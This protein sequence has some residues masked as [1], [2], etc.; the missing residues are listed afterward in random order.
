MKRR[1]KS[2]KN[3]I[4][5][6]FIGLAFFQIAVTVGFAKWHLEPSI[7]KMYT[8]HLDRFADVALEQIVSETEKVESYMVNIIGDNSIQEFLKQSNEMQ[9]QVVSPA[10]STN[11]RNKILK[12]TEYDNI[13]QAIYLV[14]NSGRVYS[15]LAQKQMQIFLEQHQDLKYRKNASAIWCGGDKLLAVYRIINNNTTDLTKKEGALCIF[16]N[17]TVF[18][19]RVERLMMEQEQHYILNHVEREF[20]L[21]EGKEAE[22]ETGDIV[23]VKKKGDWIL[24]TWIEKDVAY[25]P[26]NMIMRILMVELMVLLIISV[27]LIVFLSWRITR[28]MKRIEMAMREIGSGNM[29]IVI[30]NEDEDEMGMLAET[31][32]RMSKNIKELMEQIY[33]DENQKRYLELKAMQYQI[34]PHFLYNTLDA[35]TMSARRNNDKQSE[36]MTMALSDF[37][38][39]S[40]SH[41]VEYVSVDTEI[42]YVKSYLEIQSMRFPD[43]FTWEFNV[44]QEVKKVKILKFILQPLVENS[45][46][47]GIHDS[48]KYGHI[49]IDAYSEGNDLKIK[50]ADDGVGMLPEQLK[51]LERKIAQKKCIEQNIYEGGFGL[52]N[53]QQRLKLV[54][55]ERAGLYI[56]S[57]WDEGTE[58]IVLIP[59]I[60]KESKLALEEIQ[61]K[62]QALK[63]C[64]IC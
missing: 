19:E 63:N 5:I 2:I 42:Q 55:G 44:E 39:I 53:V 34:N 47:H 35:I 33:E 11:L 61:D 59:E 17:S 45:L 56:Q 41:G 3:K 14:D 9:K 22:I 57:E 48:G 54:Y 4:M 25:E 23:S 6:F 10:L 50:V 27:I 1:I 24:K 60:L 7:V 31:L 52:Q 40:L 28:P 21:Q 43:S 46:Y 20:E 16:I 13:I 51:I 62:R 8:E 29:D 32:N 30:E 26:V 49:V 64:K 58:I 36:E 18:R 15:N 37:F 38:R 12:Y